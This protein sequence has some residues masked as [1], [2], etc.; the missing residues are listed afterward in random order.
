MSKKANNPFAALSDTGERD[1]RKLAKQP[2]KASKQQ[3]QKLQ[4]QHRQAIL[5]VCASIQSSETL[6]PLAERGHVHVSLVTAAKWQEQQRSE[7]SHEYHATWL[8]TGI[9]CWY[10]C[11]HSYAQWPVR[12]K[13]NQATLAAW[14]HLT[15]RACTAPRPHAQQPQH[16]EASY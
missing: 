2:G 1:P 13:P 8:G 5:C 4:N 3:Q 9:L 15:L 16:N 6:F 14:L 12:S 11:T 7:A 10:V